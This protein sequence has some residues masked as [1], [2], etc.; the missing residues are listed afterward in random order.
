VGDD[1]IAGLLNRNRLTTGHGNCWTGER[2]T[3][4]RS[5]H[6]EIPVH[7][8]AEDGI[9]PWLTSASAPRRFGSPPR[10]PRSKPFTR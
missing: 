9:E 1:L 3:S 5:S 6:H 10:T 7:R 8:A 4:L 2:V